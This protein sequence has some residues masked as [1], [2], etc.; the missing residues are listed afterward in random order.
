MQSFFIEA[1]LKTQFPVEAVQKWS[2]NTGVGKTVMLR[3]LLNSQLS[4]NQLADC[5]RKTTVYSVDVLLKHTASLCLHKT[6]EHHGS[7][8]KKLCTSQLVRKKYQIWGVCKK[9]VGISV[10]VHKISERY[11]LA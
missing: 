1:I 5:S 9:M 8:A 10:T 11:R 2:V 3:N 7:D 4:Q 6:G